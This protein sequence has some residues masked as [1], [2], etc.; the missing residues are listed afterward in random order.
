MARA[1][2]VGLGKTGLSVV[3]YLRAQGA[4]VAVTDTRAEPPELARLRALGARNHR[5]RRRLRR[6]LLEHADWSW[7]RPGVRRAGR[8]SMRRARARPADRRRHRA[9]RAR[10]AR[11]GGPASPAPTARAR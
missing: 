5:A 2:V 1:V 7:C 4:P 8:S 10:S 3:R 9:V 11:A 6:A